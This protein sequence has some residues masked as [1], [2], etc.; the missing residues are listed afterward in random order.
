MSGIAIGES[1][2]KRA[3]KVVGHLEI[4][5]QLGG[6]H[7]VKHVYTSYDHQPREVNFNA[8]GVAKGGEKIADHLAKHAGL[9][10]YDKRD[11][12]ETEGEIEA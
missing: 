7:I 2:R 9:Q 11:E 5:P 10:S 8:A 1:K 4:H 6:G 3:A 12:S